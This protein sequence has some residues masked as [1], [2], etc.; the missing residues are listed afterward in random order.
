VLRPIPGT[1]G[2]TSVWSNVG[3]MQNKGLEA[4]LTTRNFSSDGGGFNWTTDFNISHNVNKVLKL[5]NGQPFTTGIRG[6]NRVAEGVPLGAFY[7]L[8]VDKVDPATGTMI[9]KDLNGDGSITSAD[10][11]IV[12]SP[13][14]KYTGGL[15][16]EMSWAGFSLHSFLQFS[17]GAKIYNAIGIFADDAGYNTDNKYQRV[18]KRW[19]KPG[20]ITD[21][22]RPSWDGSSDGYT[23]SSRHV[24]DGSYLRIQEVTLGYTLP[25]R[26][27]SLAGMQDTRLFV[28]GRNLHTFTKYIGFNPDVNSLGSGANISLGTD[29]YAYPIARSFTFGVTGN[30]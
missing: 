24:E 18:M 26:W 2:Y 1:S 28:S 6:V 16:N 13:H 22:P 4:Q 20:D 17:Q 3:N 12:G 10:R 19:Q 23:V 29:F 8:V 25:R 15:S 7:T 9:Y 30:W 27:A 5:Y 21:Q 14:P 11:A